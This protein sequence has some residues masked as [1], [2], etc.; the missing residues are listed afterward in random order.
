MDLRSFFSN[1]FWWGKILCAILGFLVAGP[2]GAFFGIFIGNFFDKGLV[3]HFTN[4]MWY[5]HTEKRQE[6]KQ[7][8]F[9]ATFNILGHIAKADGVVSLQ[10]IEFASELMQDMNLNKT[11]KKAAQD[12]FNEGK[13][14]QF[15]LKQTLSC[16]KKTIRAN[17]N[18][19]KLFIDVQ[20]I[21]AQIDGLSEKKIQIINHIL[22]ALE[23]APIYQQTRFQ[24]DFQYRNNNQQSSYTQHDPIRPEP[25]HNLASAYSILQVTPMTNKQDIKRA[26]RRLISKHHPDKL[27]AQGASVEKI[28]L[29]N[30][31]TQ[32]IR[33]AYEEIC[34]SKGW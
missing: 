2:I 30:E 33:K 24:D 16:L 19:L 18:L 23:C 11:Q 1:H 21:A 14:E 10:E 6:I 17:P 26:Y 4:P 31:K 12:F 3:E 28:K 9:Q 32:I 13:K 22:I 5:F 7:L 27:M 25:R 15:N 29:A 20:Y 8:F 34:A